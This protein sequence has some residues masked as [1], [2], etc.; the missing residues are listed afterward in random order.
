MTDL[1]L[2]LDS[3]TVL[4]TGGGRGNGA[5]LAHGFA[6]AGATV[7]VTDIDLQ[8]AS[9]TAKSINARAARHSPTPWISATRL[10]AAPLPPR[11]PA[12]S[13]ISPHW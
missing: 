9:A 10:H 4:I 8:T 13:G 6:A 12:T 11:C 7:V 1:S 2:R 5:S 3:A